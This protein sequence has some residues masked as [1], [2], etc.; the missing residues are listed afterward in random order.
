MLRVA[1][2]GAA[3]YVGGGLIRRLETDETVASILALDIRQPPRAF[4]DKTAFLRLDVSEPFPDLFREHGI[5]SV[6]H[7]AFSLAPPRDDGAPPLALPRARM[8]AP[9]R[10]YLRPSAQPPDAAR[11][12]NIHG[13]M[14]ALEACAN[15]DVRHIL[16]LSSA[17]VYGAH[18]G[19]P[20]FVTED[21]PTNP[22]F[23]FR[24]SED[25]VIAESFLQG[26]AERHPSAA[27]TVIRACPVV[28]PN[29]DNF[30]AGAFRKPI[31]PMMGGNDP[32]M[33]F[34]HEDDLTSAMVRCLKLRPNGI[35]N[36][37]ADGVVRW[38]RM[39]EMM[40]RRTLRLPPSVWRGLTAAGW[41]L[42]LQSVSPPAG[43]DFITYPWTVNSN[44]IKR[45]LG[46][47]FRHS[48]CEAWRSYAR[49]GERL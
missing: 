48:S 47:R 22:V 20:E 34:L 8:N 25:K 29:A 43:L 9:S 42:G 7:L 18:R 45:E 6:V 40:G 10:V 28:G 36:A 41:R 46:M 21:H 37:A 38:S 23:G 49:G 3:G 14:N 17:S 5:N 31:L 24:Y 11:R 35:Y 19:N 30:I 4:S 44:K 15:A 2:T 39:A 26:F 1:V 32:E 27:A 13:M 33:Q 12:V 16:Y